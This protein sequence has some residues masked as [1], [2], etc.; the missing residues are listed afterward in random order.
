[1]DAHR[2]ASDDPRKGPE[3]KEVWPCV[4]TNLPV[5]LPAHLATPTPAE[6][7]ILCGCP[8]FVTGVPSV[9]T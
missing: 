4:G 2:G 9:P 5:A 1:M 3:R 8:D 6:L 7:P